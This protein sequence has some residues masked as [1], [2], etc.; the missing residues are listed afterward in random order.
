MAHHKNGDRPS[1]LTKAEAI[2][3]LAHESYSEKIT[4]RLQPVIRRWLME[5]A[6][7]LA[8]TRGRV[9]ADAV[10]RELMVE[11]MMRDLETQERIKGR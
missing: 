4:T 5:K 11:A 8:P 9:S 7:A 6:I 2:E 10:A 1:A 3:A